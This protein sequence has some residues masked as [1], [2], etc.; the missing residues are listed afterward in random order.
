MA[1]TIGATNIGLSEL[2]SAPSG[3]PVSAGS[4]IS[5][6][7]SGRYGWNTGLAGSGANQFYTWGYGFGTSGGYLN[8][9][10]GL[11]PPVVGTN[12]PLEI[13]DWSGLQYWFDGTTFD[14]TLKYQN[15]QGSGSPP[16]G[17][18]VAIVITDST[19]NISIFDKNQG[20][21]SYFINFNADPGQSQAQQQIPGFMNDAYP[22]A[23]NLYWY[24]S[25]DTQMNFG[26]GNLD[27]TINGTNVLNETLPPGANAGL[28]YDWTTNNPTTAGVT[29]SGGCS[30]E[31]TIS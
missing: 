3:V 17:V 19:G 9:I 27:F 11:T 8:P 28:L 30:L 18:S 26:G 22:L 14:I 10:Y 24:I 6:E 12:P 31:F 15:N 7:T 13:S 21:T 2:E 1:T 25:V 5:F 4:N 16:E 29:N 20:K 23:K